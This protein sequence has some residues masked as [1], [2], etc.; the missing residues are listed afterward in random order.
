MYA[1]EVSDLRKEFTAKTGPLF[2]RKREVVSAVDGVDFALEQG[3]IFSLLGPNGA[4]KTTCIKMLATLLIPTSGSARVFGHDVVAD[5][6]R[7]RRMMTAVLPGERTLFWKLTVRENLRYFGSLYGL[8]RSYTDARIAELT[9]YF[10]VEEKLSTLVEKLSTG[11]RQKVVLCRALLPDPSLIL[12]D[13]PTLGLDPNA[14]R[15][16]RALIRGIRNEGKTVLLT[17]HYMYEADELSDRIAIINKGR[18]VALDTPAALKAS[19]DARQIVRVETD[20]WTPACEKAFERAFPGNEVELERR[21]DA[22][23]LTILVRRGPIAVGELAQIINACGGTIR[24]V[25]VEEPSLE[26]VFVALTGDRAR[27]EEP[28]GAASA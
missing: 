7:V 3:E 1:L 23:A 12:L 13:E 21:A 28:Y 16:L 14:A 4:G 8:S 6:A 5:E 22:V 24:T 2:R 27:T 25:R 19:L 17:T 18:I 20:L 15:Q 9:G 10:G 26:D 11:Q